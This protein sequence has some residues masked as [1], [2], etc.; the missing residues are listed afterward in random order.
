MLAEKTLEC[1]GLERMLDYRK[2]A[3]K[4]QQN[5]IVRLQNKCDNLEKFI[6]EWIPEFRECPDGKRPLVRKGAV[7]FVDDNGKSDWKNLVKYDRIKKWHDKK[8]KKLLGNG[9]KEDKK[10][11]KEI[12]ESRR[13]KNLGDG[14]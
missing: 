5:I 14:K 6:D 13:R 8:H 7:A 3:Y 1:K 4:N 2:E 9:K 10:T 12:M 11:F